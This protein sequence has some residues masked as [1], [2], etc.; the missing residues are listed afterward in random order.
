M[1][2]KLS[3]LARARPPCRKRPLALAA[4]IALPALLSGCAGGIL[5]PG[6]PIGSANALILFDAVG[7]MAAIV[8]P[9]ILAVGIFA[10]WFRA[11]NT[12]AHYRP[13]FVYSGR[14]E[15]IVWSIPILV[16][17]FLSGVIWIGAHQLDPFTPLDPKT[18][19]LDVDVVSL[20]WKWLFIY[21][22]QDVASVNTLTVPAG[23][24]VH[25]RLTSATVMNSFFVPQLGSMIAT[26]YGMVT[27]LYLKADHPGDFYGES[28]QYSGD[29]FSGMHFVM[30]AV[31]QDDFKR[32]VSGAR[33][34][35]TVLDRAGYIG[36]LQESQNNIPFTYGS[37][38]PH[39]FDDIVKQDLPSG[40]GPKTGRAGSQVRP[41]GEQ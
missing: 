35:G 31:A 34:S 40:P 13:D 16:I 39:L 3:P 37:V 41:V 21:P 30:H 6:G 10:W 5:Q 33:G 27:Q 24:P 38:T 2:F 18:K 11:S 19:P 28:A 32:W 22:E 14:I 12:R 9:T 8:V 1:N 17:L 4:A 7:I 15:I 20:D 36:L 26:M 29:G 25:F 23:V